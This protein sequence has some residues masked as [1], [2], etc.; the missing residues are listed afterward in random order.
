VSDEEMDAIRYARGGRDD[1]EVL[2][3][4]PYFK[5]RRLLGVGKRHRLRV[6]E[7]FVSLLCVAGEGTLRHEDVAYP[8]RRGDSYFLPAYMG[9][10]E[11]EGEMTLLLSEL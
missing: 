11:Y 4:C 10:F 2:A 7:C 9:E 8:V 5:V 6:G 3:N 1:P